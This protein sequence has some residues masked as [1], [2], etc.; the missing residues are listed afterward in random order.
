T[1]YYAT[2]ISAQGCVAE[3]EVTVVVIN[4]DI[5]NGFTPNHDGA[6][7]TWE[8]SGIFEYPNCVVEVFNRWGNLVFSSKGYETPWDGTWNDQPVPVGA[9][10]YQ[11][12]LREVEFKLTGTLNIIR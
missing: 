5:P 12:Y 10:Y 1:T 2:L 9:Y 3:G 7:E 6:N 8:I 4:L 11:I